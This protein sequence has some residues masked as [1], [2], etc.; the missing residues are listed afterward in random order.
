M[1][2]PMATGLVPMC[3]TDYDRLTIKTAVSNR[4]RCIRDKILFS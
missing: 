1:P 2:E 3:A 4:I